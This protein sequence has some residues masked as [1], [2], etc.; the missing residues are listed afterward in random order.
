MEKQQK[1]NEKNGTFITLRC[2]IYF[3]NVTNGS[4]VNYFVTNLMDKHY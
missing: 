4:S 2:I 1:F 3:I